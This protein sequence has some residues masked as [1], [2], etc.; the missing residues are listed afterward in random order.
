MTADIFNLVHLNEMPTVM[1]RK[2]GFGF[3]IKVNSDDHPPPH[4]HVTPLDSNE[5]I[6]R[7]R[8]TSKPPKSY[9]DIREYT[10][11]LTAKMKK[12]IFEWSR[13][14]DKKYGTKWKKL[15]ALWRDYHDEYIRN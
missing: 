9:L 5:I 1:S 2:D 14:P 12:K 6:A 8:I 7:M 4:A 13:L 11:H 15:V 10:G 3:E